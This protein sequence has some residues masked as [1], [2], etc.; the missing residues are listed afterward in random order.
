MESINSFGHMIS[1]GPP[2]LAV[3]GCGCSIATEA[4]AEISHIWNI[5]HVSLE[6]MSWNDKCYANEKAKYLLSKKYTY[7]GL[8][9][10]T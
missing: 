2:K 7:I 5:T 9:L 10:Q 1:T 3:L 8:P 4:V 6:E